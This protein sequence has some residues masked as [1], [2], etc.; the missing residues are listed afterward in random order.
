MGY[1]H[2]PP[3][4]A[5]YDYQRRS[6]PLAQVYPANTPG[7][8]SM[9]HGYGGYAAPHGYYVPPTS[10]AAK[11]VDTARQPIHAPG[12]PSGKLPY[13]LP[14]KLAVPLGFAAQAAAKPTLGACE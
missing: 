12:E 1:P 11:D 9:P 3:M 4:G 6:A 14:D 5:M 8:A 13:Y 7:F 10:A 2:V